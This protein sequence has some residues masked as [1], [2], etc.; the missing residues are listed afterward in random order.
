M[1]RA[2]RPPPLR[3]PAARRR[4]RASPGPPRAR[5]APRRAARAAQARAASIAAP[6][7]ARMLDALLHG[8]R[9]D[10]PRRR[11]A[12][13]DRLLQRR[14]A[15]LNRDIAR[16]PTAR[17]QL[18]R[19]NARLRPGRG[20]PRS[21]ERI[22]RVAAERGLV[23]PAARR[24][25]LPEARTRPST[26]A[27]ASKRI[28]RA[29]DAEPAP[30]RPAPT[31]R[32]GADGRPGRADEPPT[33]ATQT[34]PP[35]THAADLH[36]RRLAPDGSSRCAS[37]SAGSGCCS[38]SSC[39]CSL[40]RPLRATL[41]RHGQ[42][43][44][45]QA[46]APSSSRSRTSTCPPA[47][48]RSPTATASSWPSPRTPSRSSRNPFLIKDPARVGGAA[49]AAARAFRPTTCSRSSAT[50]SGFV[51]LRRKMD[52]V[53]GAQDREA[54]DRGDR[55]GRRAQ[56]HLP[57]G[58][59]RLAAARHRRHRQHRPLRASSSSQ[60]DT[61]GG[62]RRAPRVVKDALGEPVSLVET[63]RAEPGD[64]MRLTLDAALQ[65]RVEAVLGEV[66]QTYQPRGR[67]R[68]G[69][70]PAHRRAPGARQLAARGRQRPRRRARLRAP[71]PRG[72]VR[73]TSPARRSRRSRWRARCQEKLITPTPASTCRRAS[74]SPTARSARRTSSGDGRLTVAQ[75]L[76]QSSNVGARHDR[77]QAGRDALRPLG[78]PLRLRQADRR[79]PAR[80]GSRGS[81]STPSTTRARRWATCRS[82]RAWRSRRSRWRPAYSA[83]ADG[84]DPPRALHRRGRPP[85][86]PARDLAQDGGRRSRRC[87]RACSAAGGTAHRGGG[88]RLHARRQ[89]RHGARSPRTAATRRPSSWPRSS[90][91]RRRATRG[92][93]WP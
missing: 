25:A 23:L 56:A 90:A 64:D 80:R 9:L 48:A 81:C 10:R 51:Y 69:D 1:G 21:S 36:R 60:Q 3:P 88:A 62:R 33:Q 57:A 5:P 93:W 34:T 61:L 77:P 37:S 50:A 82:A 20:R 73:A 91:T 2:R 89:D 43:R 13:R 7:G 12:R 78:A 74:R 68:A 45:A 92:C 8:P 58:H 28:E 63:E 76:A 19:E 70:G 11:P 6:L 40:R 72:P 16:M 86:G 38:P 85:A 46:R 39:S 53:A 65:E 66:G 49:R 15:R 59:A 32:P 31:R 41:A 22:Q 27:R 54:R 18:K 55:H 35:T 52:A 47:A 17:P 29:G 87:S 26:R 14:P 67:H 71:E 30:S 24:G 75:I 44:V 42:G 4:R 83:I 84:G 79:R